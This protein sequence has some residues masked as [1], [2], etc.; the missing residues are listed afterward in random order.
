MQLR[1]SSSTSSSSSLSILLLPLL[2]LLLSNVSAAEHQDAFKL[3]YDNVDVLK[4]E[5]KS[6]AKN[7]HR[8]QLLDDIMVKLGFATNDMGTSPTSVSSTSND[9]KNF[10]FPTCLSDLNF[11]V[12]SHLKKNGKKN[13]N[14]QKKS[15]FT[16]KNVEK[17]GDNYQLRVNSIKN[18]EKLGVETNAD[19]YSGYLDVED[20]D[21]HFFFWFF[22]SRNDPSTDPII[23]WLNGGPGCSSL[24]GLFFELGPSSI[25]PDLRPVYN[26]YSW[27]K[28]AS[29]IFLDQPVNVGYSYSSNS[30]SST[31]S[32]GKDVYAFLELF[33]QK[34]PQFLQNEFHIAGESYAGHYIPQ[35]AKE[36][37]VDHPD[38]SFELQSVMIGNGL[39]D[40]LNQYPYYH[41]MAC[42]IN[43]GYESVLS[44]DE[45]DNMLDTLPRCLSLI[46]A[47]YSTESVWTCVPASL[48]CN[49]AQMG[50]YQRTGLNVY[51]IRKPC[52]GELCYEDMKYIDEYLNQDYVKKAVGADEDIEQYQSCNMEI[53][54]NFLFQGDWMKPIFKKDFQTLLDLELP[55]LIYAGDKDF[56]CNWLGNLGW[57]NE[58]EY[59]D[60]EEF[61]SKDLESWYVDG[62]E[63]G[64]VKSAGSLTFVRNYDGGHMVPYDQPAFA[65]AM[66]Q[67]WTLKGQKIEKNGTVY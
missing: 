27:N 12:K 61:S 57:T 38:R 39:T 10:F 30:V 26:P 15:E 24:T 13:N 56:I 64:E 67:S 11:K 31:V 41:D 5:L 60:H 46:E 14:S 44:E 47:C 42:G 3:N 25:G 28:N 43:S 65:L 19:Q 6:E 40:P 17:L 53:N 35:F 32:A 63:A 1:S 20:E 29:V 49:N 59:A 50:P 51:D 45:C 22:E 23:L 66:V 37:L 54:Q 33:F 4:S 62:E 18:P 58:L 34:F 48:Y 8:F 52:V 16:I 7:D 9:N 55:V 2:T 36:I 21:K